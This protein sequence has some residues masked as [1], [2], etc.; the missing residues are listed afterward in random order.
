MSLY[1][2][3]DKASNLLRCCPVHGDCFAGNVLA[4]LELVQL[5]VDPLTG[6]RLFNTSSNAPSELNLR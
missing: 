5:A 1:R 3:R 4:F 2:I 6:R